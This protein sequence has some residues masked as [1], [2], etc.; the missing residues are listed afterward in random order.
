[1]FIL[2]IRRFIAYFIQD[3]RK[4]TAS[5]FGFI[6]GKVDVNQPGT[7]FRLD[8]RRQDFADVLT[9][10]Y[11]RNNHC[12]G[13]IYCFPIRVFLGSGRGVL[14]GWNVDYPVG[15]QKMRLG[16]RLLPVTGGQFISQRVFCRATIPVGT[17]EIQP[18]AHTVRRSEEQVGQRFSKWPVGDPAPGF[19]QGGPRVHGRMEVA[20][21]LVAGIVHGHSPLHFISGAIASGAGTSVVLRPGRV[22]ERSTLLGRQSFTGRR[23]SNWENL[24]IQVVLN[25]TGS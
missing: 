19:S 1:M 9:F 2:D 23:L 5:Q 3:L 18:S 10:P 4:R 16:C 6:A 17:P 25:P 20:N 21:A 7:G 14:T 8:G 15:W 12:A 13:R 22:T 11:C 24:N